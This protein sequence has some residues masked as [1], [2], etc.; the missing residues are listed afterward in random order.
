MTIVAVCAAAGSSGSTTTS[1]L[2]AALS[3]RPPLLLECDPEGGDVAGWCQLSASPS[4]TSAVADGDRSWAAVLRH[5][6]VLPSHLRVVTCPTRG[7]Q[8]R[9]AVW[10]AAAGFAPLL[11]GLDDVVAFAD[12]GTV[13]ADPPL[14]A[15]AAQLTLLLVRQTP[16]AWQATAPRVDRA[17]EAIDV[18]RG[19]RRVGVVLIG[20]A[21]YRASEIAAV[22]GVE[23]FATL[24][25]D[26]SG[27][28]L[29]SGAWGRRAD[30]SPLARGIVEL[31]ARIDE[32]LYGRP[33]LD[34][35][36]L[37]ARPAGVAR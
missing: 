12:C 2:L 30:R 1:L 14:W 23:L 24:P 21:P 10:S 25:E 36:P 19:C 33:I 32:A 7:A 4:W 35:Q 11:G 16:W 31:L 20:G 13:G 26:A 6:Q 34:A 8:A 37:A 15:R 28:A 9:T 27:A 5:S 29:A 17:I 3:R 18:L 22:L